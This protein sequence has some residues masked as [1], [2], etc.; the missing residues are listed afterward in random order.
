MCL[1]AIVSNLY[2]NVALFNWII[3]VCICI[4]VF[5]QSILGD[6]QA[7]ST[8]I[9]NYTYLI[10]NYTN[11]LRIGGLYEIEGRRPEWMGNSEL[12]ASIIAVKH[13]NQISS[14]LKIELFANDSKVGTSPSFHSFF[15][16]LFFFK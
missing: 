11:V 7:Y 10:T 13:F 1:K 5:N 15:K 16:N 12:I 8:L 14:D 6:S 9:G 3:C 2:S 4:T